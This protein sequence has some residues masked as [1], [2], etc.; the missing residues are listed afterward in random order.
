MYIREET[1]HGRNSP[2]TSVYLWQRLA[3]GQESV[4]ASTADSILSKPYKQD[5]KERS[6]GLCQDKVGQPFRISCFTEKSV[7]YAKAIG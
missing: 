1:G 2:W 5:T 6:V 7:R 4:L 3:P